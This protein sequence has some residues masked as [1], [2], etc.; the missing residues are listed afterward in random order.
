EARRGFA[1]VAHEVRALALRTRSPTQQTRST[2]GSFTA[3]GSEATAAMAR[4]G[5]H[6]ANAAHNATDSDH[7]LAEAVRYFDQIA[8][9]CGQT[10]TAV[11]QQ[12]VAS[13]DIADK[14]VDI[15]RL[16]QQAC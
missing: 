16:A 8:D 1:A 10:A 9:S 14:V 11:E 12:R 5:Q 13:A 2:L 3:T 4:C 7:T 6:A 15:S